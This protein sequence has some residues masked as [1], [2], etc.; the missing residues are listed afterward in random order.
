MQVRTAHQILVVVLEAT[1]SICAA[2]SEVTDDEAAAGTVTPAGPATA[3]PGPKA[4]MR[5][6]W[7]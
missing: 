7:S 5:R 1:T 4:A 2:V 6:H 3:A